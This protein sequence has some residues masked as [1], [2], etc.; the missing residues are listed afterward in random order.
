MMSTFFGDASSWTDE[1]L[2]S[3]RQVCDEPA[4]LVIK[5]VVK[6]DGK[7]G[8]RQLF[9]KLITHIDM[10]LDQLPP[11]VQAFISEYGELPQWAD[12]SKLKKAHE[13]FLDHG[14][15]LLMMLYYK[16]LPLLYLCKNGAEVLIQTGRLAHKAEG[17][18]VFAKRIAETGKFLL[19]VML[20]A[21]FLAHGQAVRQILKVRLVHAS[22][23]H[24]IPEEHWDSEQL[25]LPINQE[26]LATT[27][28]TFSSVLIDGLK[29][30]GVTEQEDRL[31]AYFHL[32]QVAG[33]LLGI[34][35]SL[36]PQGYEQGHILI[37]KTL[38]RQA[39]PSPQ[40]VL[41][42]EA[43]LD[44]TK[45]TIPGDFLERASQVLIRF[46]IG[47]NYAKMLNVN[48][49]KGCLLSWMPK[50]LSQV[51]I[52]EERL[53]KRFPN[54]QKAS[55]EL[56]KEMVQRLVVYFDTYSDEEH[57]FTRKLESRWGLKLS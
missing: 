13:F 31:E 56:S 10:P 33:H 7:E 20:D 27:L 36:I 19:N 18:A 23:R 45:D 48:Q 46:L 39:A 2:E 22:I 52:G 30:F 42:T 53:E 40:G 8:S 14:P 57:A 9:D 37:K 41:L 49:P 51:F 24:F 15:R 5:E 25:G 38:N 16:S 3:K 44:F 29:Q 17:H 12:K 55:E 1:F 54:L 35:S 32:W 34:Q 26:D 47:D 4:D 43:L 6:I 28:M 50:I 21:Q 11:P